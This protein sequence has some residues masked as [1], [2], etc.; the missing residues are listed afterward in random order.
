MLPD[1]LI[2]AS[3]NAPEAG[4]AS[5]NYGKLSVAVN[6]VSWKD[7]TKA[8]RL[9]KAGE[10]AV[11][12]ETL[13]LEFTVNISELNP[14]LEFEYVRNV[15]VR[16]SGR[17][18]SDWAEIVL[19]S[20][21][22]IFGKASWAKAILS[23]PYVEVEDVGNVAGNA[24]K[25]TGKVFGVPKFLRSFPDKASCQAARDARFVKSGS[26]PAESTSATSATPA[27]PTPE[28]LNQVKALWQSVGKETG[29]TMLQSKPFGPYE[30]DVLIKLA[31]VEA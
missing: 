17:Q 19:P 18:L 27:E 20:L 13:E 9:L 10:K 31:G 29:R 6:A 14:A 11:P 1:D 15:S 3:E 28:I 7:K 12:N 16:K 26:A 8:S 21:E 22:T 2:N 23:S 30:P 5:V 4:F 24:S 25:K